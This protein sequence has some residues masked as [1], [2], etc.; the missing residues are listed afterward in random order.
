MSDLG[1][2]DFDVPFLIV[3][4]ANTD[5]TATL[6]VRPPTGDPYPVDVTAGPLEP[7]AGSADMRQR[8]AAAVPV[9]YTLP[10]KW[11]LRWQVTGTG[12]GA[13]DVEKWVV[14]SPVPGG[15][16]WSP[17]LSRVAGYV[18]RLT[19]DQTAP[20]SAVELRTFDARTNPDGTVAQQHINDAVAEV[21]AAVGTVPEALHPLATAV[22]ALRAAA[23]IQLAYSNTALGMDT[24]SI[25]A[26]LHARA[27]ADLARL[28]TAVQD[29]TD[30]SEDGFFDVVPAFA[31]PP[32]DPRFDSPTYF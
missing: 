10:G 12:E 2:G 9:A 22:A 19:V 8:W 25:A 20:G 31:F 24:L 16:V 21:Q 1:V 29:A 11:V 18:P 14:A 30:G 13:E 28:K 6:I 7:I 4:P 32:A 15:P 17:G 27:D 26:A 3:A 23:T 5:T